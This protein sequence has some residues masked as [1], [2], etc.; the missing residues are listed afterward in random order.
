MALANLVSLTLFADCM[1]SHAADSVIRVVV[2]PA[3]SAG[4]GVGTDG[5]AFLLV[6][7]VDVGLGVLRTLLA[8]F[9]FLVLSS[10]LAAS[11]LA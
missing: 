2:V 6:L 9:G 7:M 3:V 1:V 8:V 10:T 11:D 4:D 5:E